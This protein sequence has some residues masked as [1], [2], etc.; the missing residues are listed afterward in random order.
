MPT[1]AKAIRAYIESIGS[2]VT[3]AQVK[4][5]INEQ[6]PNHWKPTTL[7]AHLY[8]CVVNNPKAYVHH[9]STEKFLYR[10][11][12][13]TFEL[14]SE[15]L[16]GPNEW[17]PSEAADDVTDVVELADTSIGLE[18]DL[19][20]HLV[21]QLDTIEKGL[22]FLARQVS[23]EV[24]R[25]DILAEDADKNRVILEVKVGDAKDSSVGQIARYMGWFAKADGKTP[26]AFLIATRFPEGVQ[27]A[28]TAIPNLKLIA[29]R[30]HFSFDPIEV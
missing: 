29:Y 1:M 8:A 21:H 7:Q 4:R 10:H 2:R 27:Y 28:A 16:H 14:Y 23:T 5:H 25:I 6:Y 30:V 11:S 13:G 20:D 18:R 26:R 17:A 3:P 12:D 9:P 19:E 22:R 24:G 15:D